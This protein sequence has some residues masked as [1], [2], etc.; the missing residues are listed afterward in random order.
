MELT[1]WKEWIGLQP[2]LLCDLPKIEWLAKCIFLLLLGGGDPD[3]KTFENRCTR[4]QEN[5]KEWLSALFPIKH[6]RTAFDVQR[7]AFVFIC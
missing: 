3:A 5:P 2:Q 7:C 1:L 4:L 6:N